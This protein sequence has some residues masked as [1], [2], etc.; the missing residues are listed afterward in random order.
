MHK[1]SRVEAPSCS[2]LLLNRMAGMMLG[3]RLKVRVELYRKAM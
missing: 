3:M 2:V 1:G